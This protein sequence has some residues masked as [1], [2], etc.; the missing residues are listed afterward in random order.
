M[1]SAAGTI[2]AVAVVTAGSKMV[3]DPHW[4][5]WLQCNRNKKGCI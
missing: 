2:S 5:L 1:V 3:L 4:D